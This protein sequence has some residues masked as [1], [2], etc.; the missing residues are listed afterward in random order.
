M[1]EYYSDYESDN[2]S[3]IIEVICE[4]ENDV[5]I[6]GNG[7]CEYCQW[8]KHYYSGS[9]EDYTIYNPFWLQH[10]NQMGRIINTTDRSNEPKIKRN[11]PSVNIQE[12]TYLRYARPI[13]PPPI[14]KPEI[15]N[16]AGLFKSEQENKIETIYD[17]LNIPKMSSQY[18]IKKAYRKTALKMM[19]DKKRTNID[20]EK[21]TI[22]EKYNKLE[23]MFN[24][25]KF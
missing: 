5:P 12:L 17:I 4:C 11:T 8:K 9:L 10:F 6:T 15:K 23:T 20:T 2:S 24:E 21:E 14:E 7:L 18:E 19:A 3:E 13:T 16:W 25:L 1:D 22:Q